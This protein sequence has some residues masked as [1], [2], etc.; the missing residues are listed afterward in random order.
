MIKNILFDYGGVICDL[1]FEGCKKTFAEMGCSIEKAMTEGFREGNILQRMDKGTATMKEF[2]DG[3]RLLGKA[4]HLDDSEI[5]RAWN[6]ILVGVPPQRFDAIKKLSK[7]YNLYLLSN[8][9][10]PHWEVIFDRLSQYKGENMWNWFCQIFLSF[11]MHLE[12][13][14]KEIYEA[15]VREARI[16]PEETLFIDDHQE[17]VDGASEVGFNVLCARGDQWLEEL[18]LKS[19]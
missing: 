12:K 3:V 9:N 16:C 5:L 17:N 2:F 10:A 7:K 8:C 14:H 15:L 1:D 6:S 4:P 13:P 18:G 11:R 19:E